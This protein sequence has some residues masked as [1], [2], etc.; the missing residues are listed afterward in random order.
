MAFPLREA[1]D[2][3]LLQEYKRS[4]KRLESLDPS[5]PKGWRDIRVMYHDYI[6]QELARRRLL[7]LREVA[8]TAAPR[9]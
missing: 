9:T 8:A 3:A 6:G 4:I 7:S 5:L 1:D 2:D